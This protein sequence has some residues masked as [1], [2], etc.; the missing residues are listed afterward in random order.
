V[1][2]KAKL[3]EQA[4]VLK[5]QEELEINPKGTLVPLTQQLFN[6]HIVSIREH[7]KKN[8]KNFEL[9]I[10]DQ[11]IRILDGGEL[12]L[13]VVGHMQ[14]EIAGKMKSELVGLIRQFTGADRVLITVEVKKEVECGAPKLYTN[15]DKLN[16][17]R[18]K[19]PALAEL[20]RKFGLEAD[21]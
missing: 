9:A 18:E 4:A 17:L 15:T 8:D 14:E 19:H 1:D 6:A 5:S 3:T 12:V 10:L 13:E 2:D 16:Y 7:F 20:Q 11:E 21:F